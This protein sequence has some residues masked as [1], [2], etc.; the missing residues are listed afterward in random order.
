MRVEVQ[1]GVN[2]FIRKDCKIY[3]VRQK[4][5]QGKEATMGGTCN[6]HEIDERCT[7]S[8]SR[9]SGREQTSWDAEVVRR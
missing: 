9:K 8:C 1:E 7:Y 3:T 6:T 4:L 5:R 2:K